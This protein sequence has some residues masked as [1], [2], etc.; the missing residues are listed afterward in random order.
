LSREAIIGI[1]RNNSHFDED[2]PY[3]CGGDDTFSSHATPQCAIVG[4]MLSAP[5]IR[6]A[7]QDRTPSAPF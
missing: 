2:T 3:S 1:R 4:R 6:Q 7:K 5:A